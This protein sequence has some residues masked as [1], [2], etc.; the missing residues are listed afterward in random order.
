F[1]PAPATVETQAECV[2]DFHGHVREGL[3]GEKSCAVC[4]VLCSREEVQDVFADDID[5]SPLI[6]DGEGVTRA[7]RQHEADTVEEIP[8][9]VLLP[10]AVGVKDGRQLV[11]ICDGCRKG[12]NRHQMP[13]KS[14]ANGRWIGDIPPE[15]QGLN[16]VE[17]IIISPVRCSNI[18]AHVTASRQK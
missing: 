8:G 13:A 9:P 1:P 18:V 5:L 12:L 4:G 3:V 10:S 2:R 11:Q 15:L 17:Q 16:Y 6:R 7:A 14:L